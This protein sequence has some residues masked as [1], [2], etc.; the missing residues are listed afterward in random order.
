MGDN[1]LGATNFDGLPADELPANHIIFLF[2]IT[3]LVT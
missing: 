2:V 3:E 1:D